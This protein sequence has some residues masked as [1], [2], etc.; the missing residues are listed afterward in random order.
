MKPKES[1]E[2]K[3][4]GRRWHKPAKPPQS[5]GELLRLVSSNREVVWV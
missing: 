4:A 5:T 3:G 1:R 2:E